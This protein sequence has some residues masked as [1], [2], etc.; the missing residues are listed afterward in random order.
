MATTKAQF[1]AR[2]EELANKFKANEAEYLSA[3]FIEAQARKQLIDP[4]F[5]ALGW[6]MEDKAREGPA[7]C[8]VWVEKGE[9]TGRPDYNFRI[10]GRTR[11]FAE[12]KAPHVKLSGPEIL[13]AKRYAWNTEEV[14]FAV[15]TDFEEF[16][17]YDTTIP[18]DEKHPEL[19]L[20]FAYRYDQ[21]LTPKALTDLWQLSRDGVAAGSLD[22]LLKQDATSRRLRIPVGKAFLAD[23]TKWRERLAKDAYKNDPALDVGVLSEA[24]QVFLDRLIFIRTAEDRRIIEAALLRRLADRWKEGTHRSLRAL[25]D[26]LF[27]QINE[28]LNGDIFKPNEALGQVEFDHALVAKIIGG[29]YDGPYDFAVIGVELLGSIYERYL[30]QT[31]RVTA[32]RAIVEDKPGI[33]KAHG[34]YYTPRYIVDYIVDQTVGKIIKGKTPKEIARVRIVDPACGS[35]SFLLGAYQKLID[36]HVAWYS[37]HFEEVREGKLLRYVDDAPD[38]SRKLTIEEKGEILKNNIF[39]VDIDPQAVEITMM[40]L[41]IKALEGEVTSKGGLLPPL[42]N[43]IKCGNSLIGTDYS[44]VSQLERVRPFDWYR[45]FQKAFDVKQTKDAKRKVR[46]DCVIGNPPYV[47]EYVN[48]HPFHDLRGTELAKYYQ[49]K[50]D[51]WYIFACLSIDI[52][53]KGGLH[54]FIATNNWITN[55]G[56]SILRQKVLAETQL[57]EFVDFGDYRVFDTAGIQ[58]MIYLLEKNGKRHRGKVRY[59]R[60]TDPGLTQVEVQDFLFRG[61]CGDCAVSFDATISVAKQGQVFTFFDDREAKILKA[62]EAKASCRLTKP[63]VAQ[64]I[65]TPQD[66]VLEKHLPRIHD[67]RVKAGDGIFVLS[68]KELR[69]L[70]LTN[71]EKA[72]VKPYYT[73]GQLHR[74]Y[75][76]P[77]NDL[78]ILYTNAGEVAH[79]DDYTHIKAHLDKFARVITSDNKPYGLHRARKE[80]FFLGDKLISLRKTDRPHFTYVDFPCYVSQTFYV[81]K[82]TG[83]NLKYLAG[84]LNSRLCHFWL[85]R[86]GKKQGNLLQVDKAPLLEIPIRRVNL[87]S[88]TDRTCHDKIVSLVERMLELQKGLAS[89]RTSANR[90]LYQR[91]IE[92]KESEIDALVYKLYGLTQ[93]EIRTVEKSLARE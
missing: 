44:N 72:L 27:K 71:A 6:D 20:I 23:L 14:S 61:E 92:A 74:Y 32:T 59:R 22:R 39:G 53:K 50:M 17:L 11:F 58:T 60:I 29:L 89:A 82:P 69:A 73:T 25:L 26:Q 68:S 2:L 9:T 86:K 65:V 79:I 54:S 41:Y 19:G 85:D 35:G 38:G 7:R 48:R 70:R 78:W 77:K 46:F 24:V 13:Q 76:H 31:I 40:S 75:G 18:P 34:V 36:Y 37:K 56:A 28:D 90:R 33:H 67:S 57:R 64:G 52:L 3:S 62:I 16:H 80:C 10:E 30:G 4:L 42:K 88:P 1:R 45:E 21:Y 84:V 91:Q 51:L 47:K 43:N 87:S 63:E 49:G 93:N 15:L 8:E 5:A 81:L 12:A 83:I 55:S 66:Y